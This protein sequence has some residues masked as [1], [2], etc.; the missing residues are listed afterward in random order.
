VEGFQAGVKLDDGIDN[1]GVGLLI[2]GWGVAQARDL[3]W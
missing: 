3:F 1:L 2:E